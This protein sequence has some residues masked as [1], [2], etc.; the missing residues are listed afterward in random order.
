MCNKGLLAGIGEFHIFTDLS[1]YISVLIIETL[2][3]ELN[4]NDVVYSNKQHSFGFVDCTESLTY[5]HHSTTIPKKI[6]RIKRVF[7]SII[8]RADLHTNTETKV[9]SL[10]MERL[11]GDLKRKSI[12]QIRLRNHW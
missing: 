3:N 1:I 5:H 8:L 6:T 2:V 12:L 7:Q 11:T 9:N 4:N 10:T